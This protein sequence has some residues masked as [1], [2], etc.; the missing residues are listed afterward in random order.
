MGGGQWGWGGG[1]GLGL[2]A[3][4]TVYIVYAPILLAPGAV[5]IIFSDFQR[6]LLARS[7]SDPSVLATEGPMFSYSL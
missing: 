3:G 4:G 2:G 6:S 1:W 5:L 7:I